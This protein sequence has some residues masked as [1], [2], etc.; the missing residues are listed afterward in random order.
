MAKTDLTAQRVRELFEYDPNTGEFTH[1]IARRRVRPGLKAGSSHCAGYIEIGVDCKSYLAHRLA[2][3]YV[4]GEWP[5]YMIDHIDGDRSNNR[6][7]NLRDVPEGIN[8]QNLKRA[9]S[10]K[11]SCKLLGVFKSKGRWSAGLWL[12]GRYIHLGTHDTPELA[13]EAYLMGKREHHAG[14]TL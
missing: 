10:D 5:R 3:L 7:S 8:R 1:R 2:W 9:R 12:N 6:F 4:T 11:K 14:N 13:H